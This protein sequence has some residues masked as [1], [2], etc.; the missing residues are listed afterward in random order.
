MADN[1]DIVELEIN[2][3]VTTAQKNVN[4]L[5]EEVERLTKVLNKSGTAEGK[6]KRN[7]DDLAAAKAKLAL[8][9]RRLSDA[10]AKQTHA[11]KTLLLP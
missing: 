2:V 5:T 4:K 6:A 9:Q 8:Q 11:E 10:V 3:E 1:K 7:S